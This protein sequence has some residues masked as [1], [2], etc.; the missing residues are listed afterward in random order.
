MF[1]LVYFKRHA[2]T[3]IEKEYKNTNFK[4]TEKLHNQ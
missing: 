4:L 3:T 1:S 2:I